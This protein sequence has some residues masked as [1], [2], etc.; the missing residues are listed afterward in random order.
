[1]KHIYLILHRGMYLFAAVCLVTTST[2]AQST[3][4]KKAKDTVAVNADSLAFSRVSSSKR[5]TMGYIPNNELFFKTSPNGAV[6]SVNMME[7]KK[8][9]YTSIDQMLIGR[10]T[11]VDVRTPSA[12]PGK[13][14]SVFIRG[15]SSLLLS[16]RDIFYAQ[17]AYVVDGV[18]LI[19]DHAFAYDIQRF[20]FNRMGTETNLLSFLDVNDIESVEVLK[21]FAASAKY[22][23]NAAN[24]VINIVTK[25][26][27]VGPM[28]VSVNAYAGL[29][30]RPSVDAVNGKYESDFRLPFY[31]KYADETQW[32]NFPRYLADS[33]QARYFGPA[34]WDDLYVRNGFTDGIQAAVSGGTPYANFRFS[35]GQMSQQGVYD[36]TGIRRYDVNFG[37]NIQPVRNLVF[38]TYVAIANLNRK[39][40]EFIR[41]RAGDE[42]YLFS[43]DAPVSPNKFYLQQYYADLDNTINRNKNN[44][45]RIIANVKYSFLSHLSWNTRFAIDYGQNF[46]DFFVPTA[47]GEGN[48]YVSNFDGLNKRLLLD[49]SLHYENTFSGKHHLDVSLGQ[50]SQW[51]KWRYDYG[52]AY[53]GSSDFVKIYQPGDDNNKPGRFGNFRLMFNTKDFTQSRLASFY[54]NVGYNYD[55]KYFV[56]LYVRRDGTSYLGAENRWLVSPTVSASWKVSNEH[57]A[58]GIDWLSNLNVRGSWGRVGRLMMDEIYKSGAIYNVDAGWNGVP[59]MSTYNAFPAINAAYTTGYI[60]P[61]ISWPVVEQLNGG[62]DIGL[63]HDRVRASL[64]VYSKTDKNLVFKI[65]T[66]EEEGF[67]GIVKNGMDIRNYGYELSIAAD[68]IRNKKFQW[69]TGI[70]VYT[71]QNKLMALPDGLTDLVIGNR[72]FLVG[73][74]VDRYWLL[75]N[76]GIYNADAEVPVNPATGKKLS[77]LGVPLHKG[78]PKWKDLDGNFDINDKD[79]V[80]TGRMVAAAQGGFTNTFHYEE[81]ELN[82]LLN[83]AFGR[84]VINQ[85]LADRFDFANREGIDD[86]K[87]IKEISW[88]SKVPGDY[89]KIPAY[90]PWSAVYAYQPNQTLFLENGSYVKLRAL[91]LAYN[92]HTPWMKRSGVDHLRI[93][94]T[95]NNLLTW[96]NYKGGD[97]EAVSYFGYDEGYYNWSAPRTFTLGFNFQF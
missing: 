54:T 86:P 22:G 6:S 31:Q 16:N 12:E 51:D 87:A 18:P 27:R 14:N 29:S 32:R 55:G 76:E 93:Y 47:L 13:R 64:D 49:N 25:A 11:G 30:L 70:N 88:W 42:D 95:G 19:L 73:K 62:I 72:R 8:M 44:S 3:L 20:D 75:I 85:V 39:R 23:P 96:T 82:I 1:M 67:N 61:G 5:D 26:P 50:Y 40:N 24:G 43:Y 97:P 83:Y 91:T 77:Y 58:S 53:K 69:T 60:T 45:A 36:K 57:F 7:V 17:P 46:R 35:I 79:R 56:T 59:N 78:D 94:A 74:P 4:Y 2:Q 28:K 90:N 81:W 66:I 37:I 52:R 63:F 10:V 80:M 41:D 92:L 48:S 34:N 21:D 71:N 15:T 68:V 9:P 84:K 38:S 89:N 65:P 33:S